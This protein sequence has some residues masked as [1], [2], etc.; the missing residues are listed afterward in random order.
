MSSIPS[1]LSRSE[2]SN[3]TSS[4]TNSEEPSENIAPASTNFVLL[5]A[6]E[7][8][9]S[10]STRV[11][12]KLGVL[13]ASS[14]LGDNLGFD[15]AL[16]ELSEATVQTAQ[17]AIAR[18]RQLRNLP[19]P[20]QGQTPVSHLEREAM[21]VTIKGYSGISWGKISPSTTMM[22]LSHDSS[23]QEVWTIRLEGSVGLFWMKR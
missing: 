6:E 4:R 10:N 13:S 8:Y 23:F 17:N 18:T 3:T 7:A 5:N 14:M 21:V 12:I 16:I 1:T 9:T 19:L 11:N 2:T 22:K 15:W 20:Q